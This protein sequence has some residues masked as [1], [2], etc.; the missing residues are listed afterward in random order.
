MKKNIWKKLGIT[1]MVGGILASTAGCSSDSSGSAKEKNSDPNALTIFSESSTYEGKVGGY[2]GKAIK[3]ATGVSLSVVPNTVGGTSRLETRLTTGDLGD[4]MVFTNSDDFNKAIKAGVVADISKDMKDMKNI[5]RFTDAVNRMEK[6]YDGKLYGIPTTVSA[7]AEVTRT[8]P[9]NI[10]AMRY[11]YYKELGSPQVKNYWD[12]LDLAEQMMKTHPK[13]DKGDK[14]YGI[15]LFSEWDGKS[16]NLL[17]GL[18]NNFGYTDRDGLNTYNF[19]EVGVKD[20]SMKDILAENSIYMQGLSWLNDAHRR[21]ILDPDSASQ[22]WEDYLKKAEKGQSALLMWGYMGELNYN[23]T[24]PNMTA[25]SKGYKMVPNDTMVAVDAKTSTIGN[26]WF[27]AISSKSKKKEK[28]LKF[29]DYMYSDEG[30][31][32]YENGPQGVLWDL[33][34]EGKPELTELGQNFGS[35]DT[36]ASKDVGGGAIA[37]TFK[38]LVNGPTIDQNAIN[39][40]Y[41]EPSLRTIWTS[42]LKESATPLDKEW[43]ADY[44]GAL[45][46][47]EYLVEKGQS[48]SYPVVDVP[49][50]KYDDDLEVVVNQV[51]DVI[52]EYSWKMIYANDE[53]T[54]NSLKKEMLEKTTN[55]GYKKCVDFETKQAKVWTDARGQ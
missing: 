17:R 44:G 13:T 54:F 19:L 47:K 28:A 7:D 37:D 52:K 27:W 43:T 20:D 11:D 40:L 9:Q 45:N 33:N 53:A 38:K 1:L 22:T 12:Y 41:E 30:A 34:K 15:S 16:I 51:G 50:W 18:A 10:P 3:E 39:P 14:M 29:L 31:M 23:P 55:L 4:L 5:N 25:Q 42:Y 2:V 8:N 21:G 6:E 36:K 46:A 35:S 49:T 26:N 24:N 48:V 32:M